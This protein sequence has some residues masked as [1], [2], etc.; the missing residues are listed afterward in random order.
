MIGHFVRFIKIA[1]RGEVNITGREVTQAGAVFQ[2]ASVMATANAD[3]DGPSANVL[4]SIDCS[5]PA[6]V[7]SQ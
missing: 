6:T 3:D 4:L 5:L 7:I 2:S 1:A